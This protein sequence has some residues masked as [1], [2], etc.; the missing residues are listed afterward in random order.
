MTIQIS[1]RP[2]IVLLALASFLAVSACKPRLLPNTSIKDTAE[3]R[4]VVKFMESYK[5]AL[6]LHSVP[7]VMKLVAHDYF[8]NGGTPEASDDIGYSQLEE[9]LQ[10]T[11]AQVKSV[12]LRYFVQ[13]IQRR[14][15]KIEVVYFFNEHM[16]VGLPVGEQ[17]MAA[18][19]VNRMVLRAKGRRPVDGY[20]VVSGL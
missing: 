2:L 14:E 6:E 8:D 12:S 17:W 3:N 11:F 20:E 18:N 13:N 5:A 7:E 1:R 9:K 19:D 4:E 10:K 15:D 16:L